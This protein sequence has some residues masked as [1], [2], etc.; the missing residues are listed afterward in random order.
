MNASM[1]LWNRLKKNRLIALLAP[2]RIEDCITAYEALNPL[3]VTLEIALRTP[4]A[5]KGIKAIKERHP[6]ALLLAGTVMTHHQA[7]LVIDSGVAGVVSPDY[8][9]I[10]TEVCV[11]RDVMNIPGGT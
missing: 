10:V 6:D 2:E 8:I 1:L 4:M 5:V 3:G 9:P 7:D 11:R